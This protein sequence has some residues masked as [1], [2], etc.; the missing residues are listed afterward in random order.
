MKLNTIKE[1]YDKVKSGGLN[2]STLRIILSNYDT[3]FIAGDTTV[4][5]DCTEDCH[6]CEMIIHVKQ[7]G[8]YKDIKPLYEM[9]FPKANVEWY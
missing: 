2:E 4:Y 1:L 7:A 3:Q 5:Q 8:G 6:N 9:L